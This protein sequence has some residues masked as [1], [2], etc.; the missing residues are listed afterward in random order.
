MIDGYEKSFQTQTQLI[1][2]HSTNQLM[3]EFAY[4]KNSSKEAFMKWMRE[5]SQFFKGYSLTTLD[6]LNTYKY[7][8]I[9]V[10]R[11]DAKR[12][13]D[14][15]IRETDFATWIRMKC[16]A[17]YSFTERAGNTHQYCAECTFRYGVKGG[18][19]G[20]DR[21]IYCRLHEG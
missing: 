2:T 6:Y 19:P 12:S 17:K 3:Q 13:L 7:M 16:S 11:E 8:I 18:L 21:S 5:N 14:N 9:D 20:M 15:L 10:I 1:H 4:H